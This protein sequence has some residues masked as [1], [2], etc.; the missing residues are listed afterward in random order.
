MVWRRYKHL[1]YFEFHTAVQICLN[2]S[3]AV[4]HSHNT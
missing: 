3:S 2:N 4:Q 1:I